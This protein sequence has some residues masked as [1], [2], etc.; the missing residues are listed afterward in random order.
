MVILI[1]TALDVPFPY[2]PIEFELILRI[3]NE[4]KSHFI[5][6]P[7]CRKSGNEQTGH[8]YFAKNRT[9]SLCV[10]TELMIVD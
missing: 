6:H 2:T 4:E 10:D 1:E 3:L 8:F 9:F 7:I 5:M